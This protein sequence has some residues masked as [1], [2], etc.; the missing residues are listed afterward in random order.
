MR[1]IRMD[2]SGRSLWIALGVSWFAACS[3]DSTG[4]VSQTTG[5]QQ[6]NNGAMSMAGSGGASGNA[7]TATTGGGEG[8]PN[9]MLQAGAGGAMDPCALDRDFDGT[10]DCDDECPTDAFKAAPGECG[11]NVADSDTD[12]DGAI[13]CREMCPQD[14]NKTE[15][16]LCGCGFSEGDLDAD[17]AIDC[18]EACPFDAE[19][20]EPGACGCGAPD[21]LALC[22]RHRYSFDGEGE[23]LIDLVGDADGT[24]LNT[25]LTDTGTLTIAGGASE[26]YVVLPGGIISALGPSATIEAWV[27]WT[28]LGGSWTRIFDFGSSDAG[29]GVQGNGATYLFLT[30]SNGTDL[31]LRTAIT[32]AGLGAETFV[33]SAAPLPFPE[34]VHV[35]VVVDGAAQTLS[36]YLQGVLLGT[37]ATG[38][39]TLARLNDIDNYLGHSQ[40]TFDE[41]FQGTYEEFRIYSAALTRQQLAV[42]IEEGPDD[43]PD[44]FPP[45]PPPPTPPGADAGLT[46]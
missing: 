38:N 23:T 42:L 43:L 27:S 2:R 4:N 39:I 22:L 28:G 36:L 30:P 34:Q 10:R 24:I 1:S 25:T 26:Q 29:P 16:G 31:N 14:A 46:P 35:A 41:E 6:P 40:W 12:L 8:P 20:V 15:P 7:A 11:C 37:Q 18:Q 33:T 32:N 19:R 3:D 9:A 44:E 5:Q 21:D 17:G 13:D 45:P